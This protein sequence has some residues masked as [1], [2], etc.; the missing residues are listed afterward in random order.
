MVE[1]PLSAAAARAALSEIADP[2]IPLISITELGIVREVAVA[3][4]R[5]VVTLTPTY[6]GCPAMAAIREDVIDHPHIPLQVVLQ[7]ARVRLVP[8]DLVIPEG[9]VGYVIGSG[10]SIPNVK[11]RFGLYEIP[12]IPLNAS[13]IASC[14]TLSSSGPAAPRAY[15]SCAGVHHESS[16]AALPHN[17]QKY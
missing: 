11:S 8:V 1:A 4:D 12:L 5:V 17:G 3:G 7:P 14:T 2:E 15:S 13:F 16:P 10:D 6:S 9:R